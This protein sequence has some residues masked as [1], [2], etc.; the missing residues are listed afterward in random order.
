MGWGFESTKLLI[1]DNIE[2]VIQIQNPKHKFGYARIGLEEKPLRLH[3]ILKDADHYSI[4][5]RE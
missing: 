2:E 4:Q 1:G 5:L 3:F